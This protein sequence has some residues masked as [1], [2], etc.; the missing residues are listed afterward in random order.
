MMPSRIHK[1]L[2]LARC[3]DAKLSP[4]FNG[5]DVGNYVKWRWNDSS[6]WSDKQNAKHIQ[7]ESDIRP[8]YEPKGIFY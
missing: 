1:D 6:I 2:F 7:Y 4:N 3:D 5:P 8:K